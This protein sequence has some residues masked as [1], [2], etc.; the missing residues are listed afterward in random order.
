M[1]DECIH[2]CFRARARAICYES[3]HRIQV[4][5]SE[6]GVESWRGCVCVCV[7]VCVT[8]VQS[9]SPAG[10]NVGLLISRDWLWSSFIGG[11][12]G[13]AGVRDGKDREVSKLVVVIAVAEEV[14]SRC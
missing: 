1:R 14:G 3:S 5:G 10:K 4:S 7:C 8:N 2:A 9:S 13:D 12:I 6:K 11:D